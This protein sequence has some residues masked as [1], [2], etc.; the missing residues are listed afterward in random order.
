[1]TGHLFDPPEPIVTP[2][3]PTLSAGRRLTLRNNTSIA[4]GI[5]PAT[6]RPL[7]DPPQVCGTCT[8]CHRYT[9]AGGGNYIKC[10]R[11]RLGMSHWAASDIRASW[12]ACVLWAP[13]GDP[14]EEVVA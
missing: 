3:G 10:A 13:A 1:M 7:L 14:D 5:H 6:N 12:P 4:R 8:H 11:H 2:N 9:A